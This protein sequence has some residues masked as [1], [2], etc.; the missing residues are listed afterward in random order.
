MSDVSTEF[1]EP[2]TPERRLLAFLVRKAQPLQLPPGGLE[3]LMVQNMADGGMGSLKLWLPGM[4]T[5]PRVFG[6]MVSDHKFTDDDGVAVIAS[7]NVDHNGELME[8]DM[9]KTDFSPVI[10]IPEIL[11]E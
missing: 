2:T 3:K 10:R 1:R 6:K 5:E 8:L 4:A 7:L 11:D 9:W